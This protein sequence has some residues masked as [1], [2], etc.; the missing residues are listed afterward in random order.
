M[1]Y[2]IDFSN[3]STEKLQNLINSLKKNETLIIKKGK[4]NIAPIF[5]KSNMK[6]LF[7]KGVIL[8]AII[9]DYDLID[10]RV[11]GINMKWYPALINLIDVKNTKII[12]SALINGNGK[13]F[14]D[15]Y[16][17]EDM[18]GGMRKEYDKLNLRFIVDYECKRLRGLLIQNSSNILLKDFKILNSG[19]WNLHILYSKNVVVD[20]I[21]IDIN[22]KNSPST[23]GIDIDSSHDILIKNSKINTNDDSIAIKSGRDYD[24]QVTN[25]PS[26]NIKIENLTIYKGF[27]ITIG[28]E[29]SAGVHDVSIKNI[30][31][32][33]TDCGFRIKSTPQR[34]GY[35]KNIY[36]KNLY[37]ENVKYL[38]HIY[39]SWNKDYNN[40]ILPKDYVIKDEYIERLI[41]EA[42]GD[43]TLIK[44]LYFKNIKHKITNDY[45]GISRL[46]NI[47]GFSDQPIKDIHFKNMD[48]EVFEE[49][50]ISYTKNIK[51]D[52]SKISILKEEDLN[53]DEYDNR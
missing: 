50:I 22:I 42:K 3:D 20:N 13:Y 6:L 21:D 41:K 15:M 31:Y 52:N 33:N 17:A 18:K 53:N 47:V 29:I 38:F 49:G 16:W 51:I 9:K 36:V 24:G 30:K 23:D 2:F 32:Y 8:N 28:S 12:G 26:Y 27:G 43:N 37:M 45:K 44:N 46:F 1:K 25:K 39:T 5:L 34:K 19:F 14:Y 10:T 48:V 35:I 11:A 7:E 40:N 4:Y